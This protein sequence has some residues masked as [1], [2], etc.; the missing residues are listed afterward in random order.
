VERVRR[1]ASLYVDGRRRTR[2]FEAIAS[3]AS[4]VD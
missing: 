1:E 4:D 3:S 2:A